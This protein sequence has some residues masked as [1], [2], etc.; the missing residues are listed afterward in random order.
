MMTE[1]VFSVVYAA[2][3]GPLAAV[4][5]PGSTGVVDF[6]QGYSSLVPASLRVRG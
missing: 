5:W 1:A 4:W 3:N 2:S 6:S